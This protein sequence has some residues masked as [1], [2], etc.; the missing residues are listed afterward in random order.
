MN[1]SH[2]QTTLFM[3]GKRYVELPPTTGGKGTTHLRQSIKYLALTKYL[4]TQQ[5]THS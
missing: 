2:E 3:E 1:A 5:K 4:T